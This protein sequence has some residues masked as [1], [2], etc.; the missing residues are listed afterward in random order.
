MKKIFPI[1][2][3]LN[4]CLTHSTY[5]QTDSITIAVDSILQ[6]N[7][8]RRATDLR[9]LFYKLN[10]RI[11]AVESKKN[12]GIDTSKLPYRMISWFGDSTNPQTFR[13]ALS[14]CVEK[15]VILIVEEGVWMADTITIY[16]DNYEVNI[17]GLTKNSTLKQKPSA[18]GN[19]IS[20]YGSDGSR[21][22][23]QVNVSL[24]NLTIDYDGQCLSG[25]GIFFMAKTAI[26]EDCIFKN[27]P[28]FALDAGSEQGGDTYIN[29]CLFILPKYQNIGVFIYATSGGV[30]SVT[31]SK[32]I[33]ENLQDIRNN[34]S[35]INLSGYDVWGRLPT[36]KVSDCEFSKLGT[37]NG[38]TGQYAGSVYLYRDC[39]D[40]VIE[41]NVFDSLTYMAVGI[42][43]SRNV[44]VRNNIAR[45]FQNHPS[46]IWSPIFVVNVSK[47]VT[48]INQNVLIEN[49]RIENFGGFN[50]QTTS[51]IGFS[52]FSSDI[53]A[54]DIVLKNNTIDTS[55]IS[56]GIY[57]ENLESP[58]VEDCKFK[59]TYVHGVYAEKL[60]GTAN[61]N[62][63]D[64]VGGSP[65][66]ISNSP[67]ADVNI[68]NNTFTTSN[69]S[70][71]AEA[72]EVS[73]FNNRYSGQ[74]YH[75]GGAAKSFFICE[76]I[77]LIYHQS[78]SNSPK[79]TVTT[80]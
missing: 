38:T 35:A 53:I 79:K 54:K 19:F 43:T 37:G 50:T 56:Y 41:N 28:K 49:N 16:R 72:N 70:I 61:F 36:V 9:D 48:Q 66:Q 29:R 22:N 4:L 23:T 40:V 11:K 77:S 39:K 63:N 65:L 52:V 34:Y 80:N 58:L 2:I 7:K 42:K 67:N 46:L 55:K 12:A 1:F 64:L 44:V 14:W 21:S 27:C 24:R 51:T 30:L 6:N 10:N 17:L 20:L 26:F 62:R 59:N 3:C 15:K 69:V 25:R 57:L 71:W 32:F 74:L 78:S 73:V 60:T 31:N 5:S 13:R 68:T 8:E 75:V 47:N 18:I 76:K 45:R 33:G